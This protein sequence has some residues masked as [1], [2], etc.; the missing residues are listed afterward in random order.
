MNAETSAGNAFHAKRRDSL[1]IEVF[2]EA[3]DTG[4]FHGKSFAREIRESR[5][6]KI[7]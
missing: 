4:T 2:D 1:H 7:A 6:N 3:P 5:E